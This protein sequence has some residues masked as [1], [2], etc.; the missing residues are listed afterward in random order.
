MSCVLFLQ[1]LSVRGVKKAK[2]ESWERSVGGL[3][4]GGVLG[5]L[6]VRKKPT[7]SVPKPGTTVTPAGANTQTGELWR[8]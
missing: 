7:T 5:T 1:G 4:G 8:L 2:V 3:G 6:V